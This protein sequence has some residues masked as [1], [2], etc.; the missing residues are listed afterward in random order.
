MEIKINVPDSL[1]DISL[2]QY[3]KYERIIKANEDVKESERFITC[4]LIEIF[5]NVSYDVANNMKL[6]DF[7]RIAT[8]VYDIIQ[9]TPPLVR[10]F[11]MGES[12]FGFVPNL[13]DLTFGEYIDIDNHLGDIQEVHKAMA[14]LYRPIK[15]KLKQK[16]L[17]YDYQGEEFHEI[18]KQMPLDAVVSSIVFFYNLGIDCSNAMMTYLDKGKQRE[19]QQVLKADLQTNGDGINRSLHSVRETLRELKRSLN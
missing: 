13:E 5:C 16:Y 15:Q 9:Q 1:S 2:E 10:T 3:Q 11:K 4:K 6:V 8:K 18:M 7:E 14:V 17:L 19:V 12:E